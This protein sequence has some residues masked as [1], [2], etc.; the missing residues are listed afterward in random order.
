MDIDLINDLKGYFFDTISSSHYE[1][2][3]FN[4]IKDVISGYVYAIKTNGSSGG[5]CWGG[6]STTFYIDSDDR[7][8]ELKEDLS[9]D[10]E[11]F[12]KIYNPEFKNKNEIFSISLDL[13]NN[14]YSNSF[15]SKSDYYDYYGNGTEYD[16]ISIPFS[17]VISKLVKKEDLEDILKIMEEEATKF[18]DIKQ[19]ETFLKEYKENQ[20]RIDDFNKEISVEKVE[21]E[22]EIKRLEQKINMKT[23]D[24]TNIEKTKSNQLTNLIKRQESIL[25]IIGPI[26]ST[27]RLK[28]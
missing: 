12:I 19:K 28:K 9:S 6:H 7:I 4:N 10:L 8:S 14:Y 20:K 3:D 18:F 27:V 26:N 25:E 17:E 15:S 13:A 22:N 16:L 1:T 21:I 2:S 11:Q 24:L 23:R 5:N